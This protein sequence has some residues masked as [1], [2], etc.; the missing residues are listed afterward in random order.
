[1]VKISQVAG[2]VHIGDVLHRLP[3]GKAAGDL[4]GL[5]LT[6]AEADDVRSGAFG[7]A[8]Q[9]GVHPV[10]VMG[11]A[12][13]ACFQTAQNDGQVRVGFLGKLRVHGGAAVRAGTALAAG[14]VFVFGTRNFGH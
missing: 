6:H 5:V 10:V 9:H 13:K 2:A 1:M 11:K 4:H 7:D 3:G 8:G 12:A 14:G